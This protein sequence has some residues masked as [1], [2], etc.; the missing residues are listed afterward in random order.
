MYGFGLRGRSPSSYAARNLFCSFSSFP[1]T[2]FKGWE[3]L[4]C[5]LTE[6]SI[7]KIWGNIGLYRDNGKGNGNYYLGFRVELI[8]AAV[9]WP[10]FYIELIRILTKFP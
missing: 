1:K 6:G 8:S 2:Y 10:I 3:G 5:K 9:T 7:G 4:V